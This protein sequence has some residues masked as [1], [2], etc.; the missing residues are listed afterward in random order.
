VIIKLVGSC[1]NTTDTEIICVKD[2][3]MEH[4]IDGKPH[5]P[6]LLRFK[7]TRRERS[8]SLSSPKANA[9]YTFV[10]DTGYLVRV[11]MPRKKL[12]F[13]EHGYKRSPRVKEISILLSH[14]WFI[15]VSTNDIGCP[16]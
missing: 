3:C 4:E 7:L 12:V 15:P 10:N 1:S 14:Q 13:R 5:T 11:N 8:A 6:R 2:Q 9:F 16:E